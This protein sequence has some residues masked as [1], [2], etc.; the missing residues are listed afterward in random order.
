VATYD[1]APFVQEGAFGL[2][3]LRILAFYFQ[4]QHFAAGQ[5]DKKVQ[6]VF[7]YH[8]LKYIKNLK[9]QVVVFY[10]GFDI[11]IAVEDES[12]AGLPGLS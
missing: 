3:L 12:F 7:F 5:A 4:H 9:S 6:A 2:I 1:L 8:A 11:R 10:P